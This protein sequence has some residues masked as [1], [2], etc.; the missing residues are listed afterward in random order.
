MEEPGYQQNLIR[1]HTAKWLRGLF[2][3]LQLSLANGLTKCPGE[4]NQKCQKAKTVLEIDS[5][6]RG[7]VTT[8]TGLPFL[9]TGRRGKPGIGW[10][11]G[12]KM[13][14]PLSGFQQAFS[15]MAIDFLFAKVPGVFVSQL[16]C[17]GF[18]GCQ[19][20]TEVRA[21]NGSTGYPSLG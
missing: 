14:T 16:K 17:Q 12:V 21:A 2:L 3:H 19:E 11:F 18:T 1:N 10:R 6:F 4:R 15:Y 13:S 8:T 9:F 20:L 5:K 7:T